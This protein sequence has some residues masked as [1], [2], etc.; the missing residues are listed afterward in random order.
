MS[1]VRIAVV[2]QRHSRNRPSPIARDMVLLLRSWGCAVDVLLPDEQPVRLAD[3]TPRY[4]LVVLKSG[5]PAALSLA[6]VL[7]A[8]GCQ[9]LNPYQIAVACRDKVVATSRLRAA[10]LPV[11]E[12]W[13]TTRPSQLATLL[14]QGPLMVKPANGSRGRGV[15]VVRSVDD[16]PPPAVEEPPYLVQRFHEPDGPDRKLYSIGGAIF[17]VLRP[18]PVRSYRDKLGTAEAVPAD[19]RDLMDA[20]GAEFGMDLFGLD[21]VVSGG[22]PVAVD[23]SS[24]PGF[25]GVPDAALRLADHLYSAA[26]GH[27]DGMRALGPAPVR[28]VVAGERSCG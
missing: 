5:T 6:G 22:R 11:P 18:W 20:A 10:G 15:R 24:F 9:I 23:I 25:K 13:V 4:D 16:F 2:L 7:D 28:P 17:C 1:V 19:L 21:V 12:T 14:R 8:Q 27:R 26:G 3:D